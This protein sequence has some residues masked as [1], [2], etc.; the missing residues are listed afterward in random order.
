VKGAFLRHDLFEHGRQEH[1]IDELRI[2][3]RA[4]SR[5]DDVSGMSGAASIS[6]APMVRDRVKCI[7]EHNDSSG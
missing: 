4:A 6:I 7:R 5:C 2:E 1:Q 3:L